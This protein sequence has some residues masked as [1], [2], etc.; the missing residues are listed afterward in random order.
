M[1]K[2][3]LVL[4]LGLTSFGAFSQ[5]LGDLKNAVKDAEKKSEEIS[6]SK[7]DEMKGKVAD[8]INVDK[9]KVDAAATVASDAVK[10]ATADKVEKL[11][12]VANEK[13]TSAKTKNEEA[14]KEVETEVVDVETKTAEKEALKNEKKAAL[15][16]K[17][18]ALGSKIADAESK[19][20]MLKKSGASEEE[21]STKSKIIEAAKG[22]LATLKSSF[23]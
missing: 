5:G 14:K 6:K 2:Y 11:K 4:A 18:T 1:K 12:E 20:G 21:V 13:V 15:M 19:L 10:D 17:I 22:K 16:T 23:M 9:E 7:E 8:A 3:I